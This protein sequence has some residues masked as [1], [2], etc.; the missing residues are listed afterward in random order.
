MITLTP[1][2]ALDLVAVRGLNTGWQLKPATQPLNTAPAV[3]QLK[4]LARAV[5]AAKVGS[6]STYTAQPPTGLARAIAAAKGQHPAAAPPVPSDGPALATPQ[7]LATLRAAMVDLVDTCREARLQLFS[8]GLTDPQGKPLFGLAR[9]LA[10]HR[11][12]L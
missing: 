12:Q 3:P 4:G 9:A 8:A 2:D 10:A 7:Q 1:N 11:K 5:A 6:T